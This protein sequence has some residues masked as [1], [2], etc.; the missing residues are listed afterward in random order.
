MHS[1]SSGHF[2]FD[3]AVPKRNRSANSRAPTSTILRDLLLHAPGEVVTVGWLMESLG[4]RSF[5]VVLLLLGLIGS[6]PGASVPAGIIILL[7]AVQ[8]M[9]GRQGPMLPNV[10]MVRT[11]PRQR[12]AAMLAR[13]VPPLRFLERFIRPRWRGPFQMT[14][15]VVGVATLLLAALLFAPVP[16]SN[17]PP[18]LVIVL[19]SFAYLEE[20]GVLLLIALAL[21]AV[22]LLI[23]AGAVWGAL[24]AAGWAG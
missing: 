24:S 10:L 8:M 23:G 13:V 4:D 19:L 1:G 16:L 15:R 21:A 17:T 2:E 5:G 9:L 22:L 7:L 11:F 20:D 6:F 14:K 12:L 18:G 3:E